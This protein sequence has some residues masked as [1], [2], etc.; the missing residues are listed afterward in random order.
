MSITTTLLPIRDGYTQGPYAGFDDWNPDT[1]QAVVFRHVHDD[2]LPTNT[3]AMGLEENP[4]YR[5][6]L[7]ADFAFDL[8]DLAG[9]TVST[10]KI[11]LT[12]LT[13]QSAGRTFFIRGRWI[14]ENT[15]SF[16]NDNSI[17]TTTTV[18]WQIGN[19][20]WN[21]ESEYTTPDISA[22]IQE[23]ID[24]APANLYAT[25]IFIALNSL[26]TNTY[27]TVLY[28][29]Y[30]AETDSTKQATLEV[31]YEPPAEYGFWLTL[32]TISSTVN[33]AVLR[34]QAETPDPTAN[35]GGLTVRIF[36]GS[37]L[38]PNQLPQD[39]TTNIVE[40]TLT[41]WTQDQWYES[42]DISCVLSEMQ[43]SG[44][45]TL[46]VFPCSGDSWHQASTPELKI[47]LDETTVTP[48]PLSLVSILNPIVTG[49]VVGTER[50]GTWLTVTYP[51][52]DFHKA[53]LRL[54]AKASSEANANQGGVLVRIFGSTAFQK[55]PIGEIQEIVRDTRATGGTFTLTFDGQTT[56]PIP[57]DASAI[58]VESALKA[59]S[60][61][62][63]GNVYVLTTDVGWTVEFRGDL[64]TEDVPL[65]IADGTGLTSSTTP[66]TL[67]LYRQGTPALN[68][69]YQ[70]TF[71][72]GWETAYR[73]HWEWY[74]AYHSYYEYNTYIGNGVEP[75]TEYQV[76]NSFC[77]YGSICNTVTKVS[78][79]VFNVEF[80]GQNVRGERVSLYGFAGL[81][82]VKLDVPVTKL[83]DGNR[84][85]KS[86]PHELEIKVIG[87]AGTYVLQEAEDI[88]T[89]TSPIPYNAT[90]DQVK[91]AIQ[92]IYPDRS[93]NV[94]GY[95]A[96]DYPTNN[97]LRY[98]VVQ[99]LDGITTNLVPV[100]ITVAGL[101]MPPAVQVRQASNSDEIYGIPQ[102]ITDARV[103]WLLPA[104][105]T[106][107][108]YD[109]PDITCVLSEMFDKGFTTLYM[110]PLGGDG[111]SEATST[112]DSDPPQLKYWITNSS[113]AATSLSSHIVLLL[114][115][116]MIGCGGEKTGTL[117]STEVAYLPYPSEIPTSTLKFYPNLPS[118][119]IIN[120]ATVRFKSSQPP[121][122]I[123]YRLTSYYLEPGHNYE[124]HG[125][126]QPSG[127]LPLYA[128][129]VDDN[130]NHAGF[131][132]WNRT[133]ESGPKFV[134]E[135]SLG[136][137]W[138]NNS[139]FL[140]FY[141]PTPL[142]ELAEGT[143]AMWFA[144][145]G[146]GCW[147]YVVTNASVAAANGLYLFADYGPPVDRNLF[148]LG[149]QRYVNA[150]NWCL[151]YRNSR[152]YLFYQIGD[153]QPYWV[154]G[155]SHDGMASTFTPAGT[156]IGEATVSCL[157][158]N[159]GG[160]TIIISGNNVEASTVAWIMEPWEPWG[161]TP[162]WHETPNIGCLIEGN[163]EKTV[164]ITGD[165]L[166]GIYYYSSEEPPILDIW[167]EINPSITVQPNTLTLIASVKTPFFASKT[168]E[169]NILTIHANLQPL[170]LGTEKGSGGFVGVLG[171][172]AYG[173]FTLGRYEEKTVLAINKTIN[174]NAFVLTVTQNPP[175]VIVQNTIAAVDALILKTELLAPVFY[176]DYTQIVN[177]L[178]IAVTLSSPYPGVDD[179]IMVDALSFAAE[180]RSVSV[181]GHATITPTPLVVATEVPMPFIVTDAIFTLDALTFQSTIFNVSITVNSNTQ[182]TPTPF[183]GGL[184]LPS[185]Q[186]IPGFTG[187]AT[188]EALLLSAGT[189]N[190]QIIAIRNRILTINSV[191]NER[192][193]VNEDLL[194]NV[195]GIVGQA[196]DPV[197]LIYS[198]PDAPFT[199]TELSDV[200]RITF[201]FWLKVNTLPLDYAMI[202][203]LPQSFSLSLDSN[204]IFNCWL[205]SD[206]GY[207]LTHSAD[208][209]VT[210]TWYK[211]DIVYDGLVRVHQQNNW[212][213]INLSDN[214][215]L[216]ATQNCTWRLKQTNA[217]L[218][219]GRGAS[220]EK[221]LD[222]VID[223][224]RISLVARKPEWRKWEYYNIIEHDA[225]INIAELQISPKCTG[226]VALSSATA[227]AVVR[228]NYIAKG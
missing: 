100:N 47:W 174:T 14:T 169:P 20:S 114:P 115:A 182:I 136:C 178:T 103:E 153:D 65:L 189:I 53:V 42:P 137:S 140:G 212:I 63:L 62:G 84:I 188:A 23:L 200:R 184:S 197:N 99:F 51:T 135:S 201:S 33:K 15:D 19:N 87:A 185:P 41:S 166:E 199:M 31:T 24:N 207:S 64:A 111:W 130:Y 191:H 32:G 125:F 149:V 16:N 158:Q 37:A 126:Y 179:V 122:P 162:Q 104:W 223:E 159:Q 228:W 27:D 70:I 225:T 105:T 13:S 173:L 116:V 193:V 155:T 67:S 118:N 38:Q 94:Y 227:A 144:P 86:I 152:W 102:D 148:I 72:H 68:T 21:A 109:S 56:I 165:Q 156:A 192:G 170:Q 17:L 172:G 139:G 52:V 76:L 58:V 198:S 138:E 66:V 1:P 25:N 45:T 55:G 196:Q 164:T 78:D 89:Y 151:E 221:P 10:A 43:A 88:F 36:G 127:P 48:D 79:T 11:T 132:I 39:I 147:S 69:I 61:I 5:E 150:N 119:V 40:W 194:T 26:E 49:G 203:E 171:L 175:T 106:G 187:I 34:L 167:Y 110:L 121:E 82:P 133:T 168:I 60:N 210:N 177:S 186:V 145:S 124:T 9:A 161:N 211:I 97:L 75:I 59:L 46:F 129:Q 74:T 107:E 216:T 30:D 128:I 208:P 2:M 50:C 213:Y 123:N 143:A 18:T 96:Y 73:F 22:I 90:N 81:N 131:D 3:V 57:Y 222:G 120:Y 209:I 7:A 117:V 108:W 92:A 217:S 226:N 91:A 219:I 195:S 220:E 12:A 218:S 163:S 101:P 93:I 157:R 183:V 4:S 95:N 77:P 134:L 206:S 215:N 176:C 141:S 113:G 224:F 28:V 181:M 54:K 98:Y 29:S 146:P 180:I 190:P 204:G 35:T 205:N 71:S 44:L 83:Q 8:S 202:F 214:T 160:S 112:L 142:N 6:H 154:G 80:N 85:T